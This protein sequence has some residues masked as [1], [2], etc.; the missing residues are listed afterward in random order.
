MQSLAA[1]EI[2]PICELLPVP[3][4][5]PPNLEGQSGLGPDFSCVTAL[6]FKGM[7][8]EPARAISGSVK[9][10]TAMTEVMVRFKNGV[11]IDVAPYF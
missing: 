9:L 10:A 1:I 5:V 8:V 4:V 7:F 11:M 2:L 6:I 3:V